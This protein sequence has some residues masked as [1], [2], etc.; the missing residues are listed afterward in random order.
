MEQRLR[1]IQGTGGRAD[2]RTAERVG[3]Q[4]PGQIV[5]KDHRG[6]TQMAAVVTRDVSETG[7][8]IECRTGLKLPLYRL[9]YFQVDRLARHRSEVPATLRKQNVLSAVFRIGPSSEATGTPT[10]YGLR[11]LVD[12]QA[13][14]N[15]V[16]GWRSTTDRTRTA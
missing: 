12:P 6:Q 10:E 2:K 5:W 11:L 14:A 16:P 1:L 4:V 15:S 3:L 13:S 7:V 8:R 9:V